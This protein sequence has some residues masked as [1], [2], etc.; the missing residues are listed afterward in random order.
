MI[1]ESLILSRRIHRDHT[2]DA[3]R[4]REKHMKAESALNML[5]EGN[6]RFVE[7]RLTHPHQTAE[8]RI[9][10]LPGQRPFA[11]VLACSDSRVVPEI[12][13]DRGLGDL[14][15]VRVAGNVL[16]TTVLESLE[17]SAAHLRL[18][19]I[20]VLGHTKC[21]A[22]TAAVSDDSARTEL[23]P[24][25]MGL[26]RPAVEAARG[27]AGDPVT[28]AVFANVR[29]ALGA[30]RRATPPILELR[31]RGELRI[32]GAVY[33]ISTGGVEWLED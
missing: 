16:D 6:R 9:E 20:V 7:D 19:L 1:H 12:L 33:D 23:A 29:M 27:Q 28:N 3:P 22:L 15:V 30:L 24:T 31:E 13:F 18:P 32:V 25:L 5:K 4:V 11:S 14:F 10:T 8:R 17:F 21:G 2:E 26:L